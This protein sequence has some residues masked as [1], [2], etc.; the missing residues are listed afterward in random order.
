M[1]FGADIDYLLLWLYINDFKFYH[2]Q[3]SYNGFGIGTTA[4]FVNGNF[5][6]IV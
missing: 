2:M 3:K 5:L 4:L 1:V 6:I